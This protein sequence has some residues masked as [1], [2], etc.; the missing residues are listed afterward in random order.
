MKKCKNKPIDEAPIAFPRADPAALA[1][2]DERTKQCHM[3][4]GRHSLDPRTWKEC[5]F[6]CTDC[7]VEVRPLAAENS[8]AEAWVSVTRDL[9]EAEAKLWVEVARQMAVLWEPLGPVGNGRLRAHRF[10]GTADKLFD[11]AQMIVV[12]ER[13]LLYVRRGGHS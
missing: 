3:Q 10:T 6:L 9:D 11:F 5:L 1:Q 7:S 4:C 2:F 8:K 13:D 12:T